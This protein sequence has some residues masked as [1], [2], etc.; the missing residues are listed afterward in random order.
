MREGFAYISN[1]LYNTALSLRPFYVFR[2]CM[3][4]PDCFPGAWS[5][6]FACR[7]FVSGI[8]VGLCV[9]FIRI[10]FIVFVVSERGGRR[11]EAARGAKRLVLRSNRLKAHNLPRASFVCH[12]MSVRLWGKRSRRH[13]NSSSLNPTY[14]LS[15]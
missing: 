5:L 14:L 7:Q 6:A 3:R 9:R 8:F 2:T 13:N 4:R 10:L 1:L 15:P 12:S 11:A